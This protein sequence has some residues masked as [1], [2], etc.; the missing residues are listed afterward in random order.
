VNIAELLTTVAAALDVPA[1]RVVE[2]TSA[3]TLDEWDSLGHLQ[4]ILAV[5]KQFGVRFRTD[6]LADLASIDALRGRL[7]V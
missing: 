7:D 6:E 4:V 3:D 2:G 1:E 5:E